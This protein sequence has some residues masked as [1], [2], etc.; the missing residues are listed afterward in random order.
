MNPFFRSWN[1]Q[2]VCFNDISMAFSCPVL[3]S[4]TASVNGFCIIWVPVLV[5]VP[6]PET[7]RVNTPS[8]V[9]Y[10]VRESSRIA[11]NVVNCRNE[12][13]AKVIFLQ[14]FVCPQGGSGPGGVCVCG[15]QFFGGGVVSNFSGGLQF[16]GGE[17]PTGIRSTFGR[18]A[19]YWNAFLFELKFDEYQKVEGLETAL[20]KNST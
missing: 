9:K 15:L 16:F 3:A 13:L 1:F 7:A 10:L 17:S 11:D 2:V 14:A 4:D 19:S 12:V 6:V 20:V 8:G 18:Y 5:P